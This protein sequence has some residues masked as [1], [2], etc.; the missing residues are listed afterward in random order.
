MATRE[1]MNKLTE[2]EVFVTLEGPIGKFEI[3]T[4][5][6]VGATA[7]NLPFSLIN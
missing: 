3:V 2:L 7:V 1:C 5:T 6:S 4:L